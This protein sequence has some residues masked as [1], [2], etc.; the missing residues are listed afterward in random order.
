M[1]NNVFLSMYIKQRLK[2]CA[3]YTGSMFMVQF[4]EKGEGWI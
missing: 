2:F 3:A 4:F 1:S